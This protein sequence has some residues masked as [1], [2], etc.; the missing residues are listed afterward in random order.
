[1]LI[2]CLGQ[3]FALLETAYVITRLLQ[4]YSSIEA[5]DDG[6]PWYENLTLTCAVGQGVWLGLVVDK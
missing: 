5:R 4:T 6:T 2:N 1:M 3:Q